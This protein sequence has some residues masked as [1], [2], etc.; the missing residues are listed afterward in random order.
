MSRFKSLFLF[1]VLLIGLSGLA[2]GAAFAQGGA[3][4][5]LQGPEQRFRW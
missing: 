5:A 1:A 2:Q 4:V 3:P